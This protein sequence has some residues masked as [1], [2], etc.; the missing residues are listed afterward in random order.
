MDPIRQQLIHLLAE[1]GLQYTS[2]NVATIE[3]HHSQ[4]IH[5]FYRLTANPQKIVH[6]Q[7]YPVF[8]DSSKSIVRARLMNYDR[9][10][11]EREHVSVGNEHDAV[12][13]SFPFLE[14]C[15]DVGYDVKKLETIIGLYVP[16]LRPCP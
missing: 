3:T 5:A 4:D 1:L 11:L 2:R 9:M 10:M 12:I 7:A 8:S 16:E 14:N 6:V 13:E 15:I